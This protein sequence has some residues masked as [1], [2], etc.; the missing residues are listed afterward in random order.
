[1]DLSIDSLI[2]DIKPFYADMLIRLLSSTLQNSGKIPNALK[3][4]I[5]LNFFQV[6]ILVKRKLKTIECA[7]IAILLAV[8]I[9]YIFFV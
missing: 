7:I 1:M 6:F 8:S 2:C 5:N 4:G 3:R 9:L